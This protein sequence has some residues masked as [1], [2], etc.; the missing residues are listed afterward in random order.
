MTC[1][2]AAEFVSAL[3]D[4]QTIPRE[5]AE[6]VGTCEACQTRLKEY[7]EMSAELRRVASLEWQDEAPVRV[8]NKRQGALATWWQKGWEK[9]RIPRLAFAAL[10]GGVVV[11]GCSLAVVGVRARSQGTV[12]LLKIAPVP[13]Q[14]TVCPLSTEDKRWQSCASFGAAKGGMLTYQFELLS[15]DGDHVNLGVRT[16]FTPGVAGSHSFNYSSLPGIPQKQYSF[17]PGETLQVDVSGMGD[18]EV[19]G[20]WMD[21]VPAVLN[22]GN[23]ELDPG[24]EEMRINSP[25]LLR[26]KQVVGD[27]EGGS[28]TE[29][30]PEM[31]V[32]VY[33]PN[34]GR[35][36]LSLSPVAGAI[37]GRVRLNR[38]SFEIDGQPYVFVTGTPITRSDRV[39]I[40]HTAK[41]AGT[42]PDSAFIALLNLKQ[43]P[44]DAVRKN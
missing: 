2:E 18:I 10:L 15:K 14:S 43:L 20:E 9:M 21:H 34:E 29:D 31:G 40:L 37:E 1:N 17:E 7:M 27:L 33:F 11:L 6:H 35:F 16:Q 26:G 12:V 32:M 39:W 13:G 3:C 22:G 23:R 4:G 8:W 41:P 28:A 5:A 38:I 30:K 24:P 25:V 44:S 42:L 19:T 36:I